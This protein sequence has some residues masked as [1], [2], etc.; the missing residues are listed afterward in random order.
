MQ[1]FDIKGIASAMAL[2]LAG[3]SNAQAHVYV[4]RST[5]AT[6]AVLAQAPQ[7][8]TLHFS[9]PVEARF[10]RYLLV[11]GPKSWPLTA[12]HRPTNAPVTASGPFPPLGPGQYVL[13]WS[14]LSR[15]G[16]RQEGRIPFT[17]R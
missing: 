7:R 11:A 3:M 6:G 17:V 13:R 2:I 10:N 16:H 4:L 5:P 15:D 9:G 12:Q 8:F 14:A 1:G